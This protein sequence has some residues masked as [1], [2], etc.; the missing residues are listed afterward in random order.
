MSKENKD[1][2]LVKDTEN[3]DH[4]EIPGIDANALKEGSFQTVHLA[5]GMKLVTA[6]NKDEQIQ[7]VML[8]V[9]KQK[10]ST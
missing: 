8:L 6:R 3:Y 7:G 2:E 5:D 9:P 10:K 4:F 1:L